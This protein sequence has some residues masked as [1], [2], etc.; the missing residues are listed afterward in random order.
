MNSLVLRV[1]YNYHMSD[2]SSH[3]PAGQVFQRLLLLLRP[4]W[5]KIALGVALLL[6][7]M[8]AELFPAF[9]WLYVADGLAMKDFTRP[10][11]ILHALFSFGGRLEGWP[12]L[13]ASSLLW[14]TVIYVLGETLQTLSGWIMQRVAQ[15]FILALRNTVYG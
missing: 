9:V 3:L 6:L 11:R 10:V 4:Q 7:S 14:L 13:L 1:P 8:P 2:P 12:A 5:G 15:R